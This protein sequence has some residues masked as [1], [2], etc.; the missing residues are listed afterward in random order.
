MV[1]LGNA[2][3][4]VLVGLSEVEE[5]LFVAVAVAVAM[6][7]AVASLP[8]VMGPDEVEATPVVIAAVSPPLRR[9]FG[10]SPPTSPPT[11]PPTAR[12][13][14]A[15]IIS[16]IRG[17]RPHHLLGLGGIVSRRSRKSAFRSSM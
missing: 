4:E 17:A 5:G 8:L 12:R 13:S 15:V 3:V 2:V 10:T 1:G 11:K 16:A 7:V 14:T 6:A 9:L